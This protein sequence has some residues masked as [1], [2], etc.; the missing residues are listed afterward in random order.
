MTKIT[1]HDIFNEVK[2]EIFNLRNFGELEVPIV[3]N[4]Y[5]VPT[6][7]DMLKAYWQ[8]ENNIT[9][10]YNGQKRVIPCPITAQNDEYIARCIMQGFAQIYLGRNEGKECKS[11]S[12]EDCI[13]VMENTITRLVNEGLMEI[14]GQDEPEEE[15][16]HFITDNN[17][18][19]LNVL[20]ELCGNCA[21]YRTCEID[22]YDAVVDFGELYV[23]V[24]M[25]DD[26]YIF[27]SKVEGSVLNNK[28][29]ASELWKE[30]GECVNKIN[31][32]NKKLTELHMGGRTNRFESKLRENHEGFKNNQG[33]THF[34]VNKST[35]KIVNG[36]DYKGY[37]PSDLKQF[38]KDYF[39]D[40]LVNYGLKP[41]LY[42]IVTGKYLLKKGI[43]PDDN[44]NW[45]NA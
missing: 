26:G 43:D 31:S 1:A 24:S 39:I 34:A 44:G 3:A 18:I 25:T 10:T 29:E 33:Y 30:V 5:T 16:M 19:I 28:Q 14:E 12:K 38:K 8:E 15:E 17:N 23:I 9:V 4:S 35:G 37:E 41:K 2:R 40:D 45:A 6:E 27:V 13:N 7:D 42:K 32:F 11:L 22:R 36:W 20:H 21:H